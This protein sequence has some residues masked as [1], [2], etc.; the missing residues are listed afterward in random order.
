MKKLPIETVLIILVLLLVYG[1]WL[2]GNQS[3]SGGDWPFLFPEGMSLFSL[4]P[5]SVRVYIGLGQSTLL[6]APIE[7]Y[8]QASARIGSTLGWP[9]VER[10]FWFYPI[11]VLSMWSS[12]RLTRSWVGVLIYTTNTY[13]LMLIGGGQLGVALAYALFPLFVHSWMNIVRNAYSLIQTVLFSCLIALLIACDLRIAY[14]AGVV[15]AVVAVWEVRG[16]NKIVELAKK[17]SI[18]GVIVICLHAFWI[19]PLFTQGVG[20]TLSSLDEVYTSI[21]A[22]SYFSVARFP[23][24]FSLLHPNWPENIFGKVYLMQAEFL[25][26]SIISFLS[27]YFISSHNLQKSKIT[28]RVPIVFFALIGV[29]GAFLAKGVNEPLGFIY[30]FLF[31][32]VPGFVMFRDPTKWY[33]LVALS[34][35]L[36]IPFSLSSIASVLHSKLKMQTKK[37]YRQTKTIITTLFIALWMVLIRE[38]WMG[39]L[40]GTFV[41]KDV[42]REYSQLKDYI[43]NQHVYSRT[44]WIP[45]KQR[46]GYFSNAHPFINATDMLDVTDISAIIAW[47][48]GPDA[49]KQLLAWGVSDVIVPLDSEKELFLKERLYCD[50]CR[51]DTID[52]LNRVPWLYRVADIPGNAVYAVYGFDELAVPDMHGRSG[53]FSEK[54]T[55]RL[56]LF[57]SSISAIYVILF[58]LYYRGSLRIGPTA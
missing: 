13:I 4:L 40:T 45:Q 38:A 47:V 48:S 36:M 28:Q 10:L 32:Q 50:S 3:L 30:Q 34:Y 24:A 35:S 19:V 37:G 15:C 42:P 58:L 9:V 1:R 49:H 17:S 11:V 54:Q 23:Q 51:N 18:G 20:S 41:P 57:I 43:H 7:W 21:D 26:I 56:G 12:Y 46:F 8:F 29:M 44:F 33:V 2:T 14:V 25:L 55:D 6:F 39:N 27:L 53:V 16:I 52:T 5:Q 22:L 31:E